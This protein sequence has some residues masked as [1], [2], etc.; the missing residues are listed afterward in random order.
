MVMSYQIN[1][2]LEREREREREGEMSKGC[3]ERKRYI[4]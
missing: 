2:D 3:G 1:V 4:R